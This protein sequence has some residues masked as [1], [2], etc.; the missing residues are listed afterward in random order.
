M[1]SEPEDGR[2]RLPDSFLDGH[3]DTIVFDIQAKIKSETEEDL[4]KNNRLKSHQTH[5]SH[6]TPEE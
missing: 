1:E 3:D 6:T 5:A 4:I 2:L